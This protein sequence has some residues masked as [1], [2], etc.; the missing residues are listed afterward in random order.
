QPPP[1]R[2]RRDG[3]RQPCPLADQ[4][5]VQNPRRAHSPPKTLLPPSSTCHRSIVVAKPT[6]GFCR[7]DRPLPPHARH[8]RSSAETTL[9]SESR[10]S[11]LVRRMPCASASQGRA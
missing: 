8:S 10:K 1:T 11:R 2:H 5:R 9:R 3:G 7:C 4:N 6:T